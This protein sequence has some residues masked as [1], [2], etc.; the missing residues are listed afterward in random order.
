MHRAVVRSRL[1]WDVVSST[2]NLTMTFTLFLCRVFFFIL[3][4]FFA[5]VVLPAQVSPQGLAKNPSSIFAL[6]DPLRLIYF[7][8]PW[9]FRFLKNLSS[10]A[11]RLPGTHCQAF[12]LPPKQ[13]PLWTP[14]CMWVRE[15]GPSSLAAN[16]TPTLSSSPVAVRVPWPV[17]KKRWTRVLLAQGTMAWIRPSGWNASAGLSS[18]STEMLTCLITVHPS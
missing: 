18:C 16:P 11:S 2:L 14:R 17:K 1:I 6:C 13:L 9:L 7:V 3:F 15:T 5:I 10:E 8:N 4:F 12:A